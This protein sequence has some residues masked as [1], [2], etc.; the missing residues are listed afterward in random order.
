M[1]DNLERILKNTVMALTEILSW[2]LP[3]GT[4]KTITYMASVASDLANIEDS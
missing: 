3:G 2:Q 1:S 4:G